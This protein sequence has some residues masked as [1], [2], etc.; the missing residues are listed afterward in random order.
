MASLVVDERVW[1][2]ILC[3]AMAFIAIGIHRRP[4]CTGY[5]A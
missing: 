5:R 3:I 4:Q 1:E 2:L